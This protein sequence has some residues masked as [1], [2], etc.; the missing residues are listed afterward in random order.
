MAPPHSI[1]NMSV[2]RYS[3]D[4]TARVVLWENSTVP[5]LLKSILPLFLF[6]NFIP[7]SPNFGTKLFLIF[8]YNILKMLSIIFSCI[9]YEITFRFGLSIA[10]YRL[11]FSVYCHDFLLDLSNFS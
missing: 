11:F 10:C 8:P 7:S 4:N 1:P 5:E 9:L 2:K 6:S 3:G